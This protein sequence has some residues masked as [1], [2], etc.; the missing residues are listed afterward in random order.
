M[1]G[2][3]EFRAMKHSAVYLAM[4]YSTGPPTI[5]RSRVHLHLLYFVSEALTLHRGYHPRH[6]DYRI[7]APM[8]QPKKHPRPIVIAG[9]YAAIL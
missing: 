2:G 9:E 7:K 8:K 5:K 4:P 3:W 6:M 1:K